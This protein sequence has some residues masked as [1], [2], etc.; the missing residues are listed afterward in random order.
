MIKNPNVAQLE[1]SYNAIATRATEG[2]PI[3][4][5]TGLAIEAIKDNK[6]Y[7][8]LWINLRT[9]FRNLYGAIP[10]EERDHLCGEALAKTLLDEL[11]FIRD[12]LPHLKGVTLYC[13]NYKNLA[14]EFPKALI[15]TPQTPLQKQQHDYLESVIDYFKTSVLKDKVIWED[16]CQI[17]GEPTK[18][19]IITNYAVDLLSRTQFKQLRLLESYTGAIKG[20]SQWNTKLTGGKDLTMMPFC[21]FTLQIFGDNNNQFNQF[22]IKV[23]EPVIKMALENNWTSIT[24]TDK[25]R[26][27]IRK[28][29]D[30]FSA[31]VL[32][33]FL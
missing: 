11:N 10:K 9:L 20:R 18:S 33:G 27:N 14:S 25:I 28:M 16:R 6:S 1:K 22:G 29:K 31:K 7:E 23:R 17:R 3:S 4:V 21:K 15:R 30:T 19:L 24:T 2:I 12:Y 32:E 26:W 13:L 8:T 5:G